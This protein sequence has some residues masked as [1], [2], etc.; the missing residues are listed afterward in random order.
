MT[1]IR[2][3]K[4]NEAEAYLQLLCD[5]FELDFNR[6]YDLFFREPMFDL[7]RKWAMFEGREIVS[8]LTTTPLEFGWGKACGIA[9]VATKK[10][11]QGEGLARRVIE[12]VLAT[13][14]SRGE[15][16]AM[17]FAADTRLY[18]AIGFEALDRVVRGTV[19]SLPLEVDQEECSYA[20]LRTKYDAWAS[21]DPDRLRRD[22][23]RWDYWKW[24]FRTANTFRDGY[25]TLENGTV[26]EAIFCEPQ[27]KLPVPRGTEW[28]GLSYVTDQLEIPLGS[29]SVPMY[30]MGRNVP[31]QPQLF[32]TDQF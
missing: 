28:L 12:K 13:S 27:K 1:E 25:Y 19:L 22:E 18:E 7:D 2:P 21:G 20:S 30:L 9:G 11:R 16:A 10:D 6:A 26:R 29:V 24:N 31:G 14:D 8:I 5:V 23:Q 15:G 32:M 4:E 3:I 17:L